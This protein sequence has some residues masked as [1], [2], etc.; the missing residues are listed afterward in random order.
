MAAYAVNIKSGVETVIEADLV[1]GAI[2]DLM[3]TTKELPDMSTAGL[4][5]TLTERVG[6]KIAK[7]SDWP[8]TPHALSGRLRRIATAMRKMGIGISRLPRKNQ[9]RPVRIARLPDYESNSMSP[10]SQMSRSQSFQGL[11]RDDCGDDAN[12]SDGNVTGNV[13]ENPLKTNDSDIRDESD[14]PYGVVIEMPYAARTKGVL[15]TKGLFDQ[16]TDGFAMR[17]RSGQNTFAIWCGVMRDFPEADLLDLEYAAKFAN[18]RIRESMDQGR[19]KKPR[20]LHDVRWNG[21]SAA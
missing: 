21:G 10:K 6:E 15:V 11:G 18:R 19:K 16:L 14:V 17:W 3:G 1:A 5:A 13:T 12:A 2:I 20:V 4:L 9:T 8:K 7:Q